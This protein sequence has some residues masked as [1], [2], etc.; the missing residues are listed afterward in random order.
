MYKAEN[1]FA[2]M[3]EDCTDDL[4]EDQLFYLKHISRQSWVSGFVSYLPSIVEVETETYEKKL[5]LV[6]RKLT[7]DQ[8]D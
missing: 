7:D 1:S 8:K 4:D 2:M 5:T 6:E 3:T